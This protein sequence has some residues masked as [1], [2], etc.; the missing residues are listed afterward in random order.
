MAVRPEASRRELIVLA[1]VMA[2]GLAVRVL[3]VLLTQD[4][5][6]V[7]DQPEYDATGRLF[8]EGQ[9]FWGLAPTGEPHE[10]LWK[11][12]GYGVWVGVWYT[13][14]GTDPLGVELVQAGLGLATIGLTWI[15]ARRLFGPGVALAAAALAAVYPLVWQFEATLYPEAL[16]VPITLLVLVL[17]LGR[18]PTARRAVLVGAVVGVALLIRPTSFFLLVPIAVAWLVA[19]GWRRG[20]TATALTVVAATLVVAPWTVRNYV[21]ADAFVPISV[22]NAAIHGTF[23]ATSANDPVYP[24]AWRAIT[25]EGE[26]LIAQDPPPSEVELQSAFRE[27]AVDYIAA[28]PASVPQAFFWN[29]LSRYWDMRNPALALNEVAFEGRNRLI[30]TLGLA[31]YYV[32]L[33]L[34]VVGL[35]R[36]RRRRDLLLP[37]LALALAASVVFTIAS[38]TRY[39][40]PIEPLI[41]VLACSVFTPRLN[42]LAARLGVGEISAVPRGDGSSA[43]APPDTV[44]ATR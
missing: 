3:A 12:P 21:V 9:P 33:P 20:A 38:G 22:Q 16:A 19:A 39:R 11:A 15:L 43:P 27:L 30:T 34:A 31:M 42:A 37:V 35:F 7:G 29:G 13:L 41:V 40:A 26:A 6:L 36:L 2:V 23:N 32:L 44:P 1:A 17:V 8:A 14:L 24:Y 28:N 4:M 10:S 18:E 25:P 5:P